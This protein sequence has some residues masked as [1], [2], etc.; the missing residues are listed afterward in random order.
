L[1]IIHRDNRT[2]RLL[3]HD[4]QELV[5]VQPSAFE[6]KQWL[7]SEVLPLAFRRIT[8][9]GVARTIARRTDGEQGAWTV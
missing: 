3:R 9:K 6:G 8:S 7:V 5:L 4:G 1:L 2:L